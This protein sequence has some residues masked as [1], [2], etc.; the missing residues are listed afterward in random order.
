MTL[1]LSLSASAAPVRCTVWLADHSLCI[2]DGT[3]YS[4]KIEFV[5]TCG[6]LPVYTALVGANMLNKT[7]LQPSLLGE[8]L[9]ESPSPKDSV[10]TI[11]FDVRSTRMAVPSDEGAR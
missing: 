6:K 2:F 9:N 8:N 1:G 4:S 11:L 7:S 5:G 3:K 10:A